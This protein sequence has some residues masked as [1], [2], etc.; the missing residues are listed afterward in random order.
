MSVAGSLITLSRRGGPSPVVWPPPPREALPAFPSPT[1]SQPSGP[2]AECWTHDALDFALPFVPPSTPT[3]DFHRGN[4]SGHRVPGLPYVPGCTQDDTSL[5]MTWF[6]Y[7][8]DQLYP[9]QGFEQRALD[10]YQGVAG[11]T[12]IDFHRADWMGVVD[13]VPGCS[14][15][16]ALALVERCTD[17]G[18]TVI[19]NL[20]IY[21]KVPPDPNEITPWIDDLVSAGMKIGCIAW[22]IN[23][24]LYWPDIFDYIDWVCPY[25]HDKGVKTSI[26]W[27]MDACAVWPSAKF[28]VWSRGDFQ[29]WTSDKIDYVYEQFNTEMPLL[30]VRPHAGGI[31]GEQ[32]DVLKTL[33]AQKLVACEYSYQSQFDDPKNRLELYADLKGRSLMATAYNGRYCEGGYLGGARQTNGM[34]L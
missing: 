9:G 23:Q 6:T 16:D 33:A 32:Q 2:Y 10:S 28:N 20:A 15:S 19:V 5:L 3:L 11:Y 34:V 8:Y 12:H 26:Q 24:L 13:G 4:V 30:D 1:D 7:L 25:L 22:Q 17:R 18:L 27:S 29:Q 14:K 31:I 21:D